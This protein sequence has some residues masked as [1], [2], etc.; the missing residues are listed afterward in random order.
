[1]PDSFSVHITGD[2]ELILELEAAI[3]HAV[4]EAIAMVT[5]GSQN[6]RTDWRKTWSGIRHAPR[7]GSSLSYDVSGDWRGVEAEI[8]A[9]DGPAKQGFLAPIF[10]YGGLHSPPR[11]GGQP[12][13]EAEEPRLT[14]AAEA[15][16]LKLLP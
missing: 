14:A 6:I 2:K 7:L 12:A 4:P 3:T 9:D 5:K 10:E 15:L 16:M 1:M 11:P 8:G 13:L